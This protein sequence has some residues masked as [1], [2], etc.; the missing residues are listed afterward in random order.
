MIRVNRIATALGALVIASVVGTGTAAIA[1][2]GFQHTVGTNWHGHSVPQ[3]GGTHVW[4]DHDG[5]TKHASADVFP[6]SD[7]VC[8]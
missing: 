1:L 7:S 2:S 5:G 3:G 6:T 8:R 4:T